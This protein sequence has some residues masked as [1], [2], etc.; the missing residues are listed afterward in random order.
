MEFIMLNYYNNTSTQ[1]Y[2][3][4]STSCKQHTFKNKTDFMCRHYKNNRKQET[5]EA[6]NHMYSNIRASLLWRF[7]KAISVS[8]I[9]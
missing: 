4:V 7:N 3:T 1:S 9:F 6:L 5:E 8:Y 2:W